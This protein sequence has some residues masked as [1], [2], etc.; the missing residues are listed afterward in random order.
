MPPND[1]SHRRWLPFGYGWCAVLACA[2]TC[3]IGLLFLAHGYYLARGTELTVAALTD[4]G[5][6]ITHDM[7][8][9]ENP[10]GDTPSEP[11]LVRLLGVD[12]FYPVSEVRLPA[13][14]DPNRLM[15]LVAEFQGVRTIYLPSAPLD[16]RSVDLLKRLPALRVVGW[17]E[18][19]PPSVPALKMVT[20]LNQVATLELRGSRLV[21]DEHMKLVV[22]MSNIRELNIER[23]GVT[24]AGLADL[25]ALPRLERLYV[26]EARLSADGLGVLATFPSLK[27]LGIGGLHIS[28]DSLQSLQQLPF[29]E[30]LSLEEMRIGE[31]GARHLGKLQSLRH[32]QLCNVEM[33]GDVEQTL[34]DS[35]PNCSFLRFN[36]NFIPLDERNDIIE[37]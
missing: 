34:R 8:P 17:D 24:N 36:F 2:A 33:S 19:N 26:S 5:A 23:S 6:Q 12:F 7:P 28:D 30:V 16:S 21:D 9:V 11:W 13:D 1:T 18:T 3:T 35:L 20:Q 27:Q 15:P 31:A 22:T 25:A 37:Q 29:L 10:F 32:L 14:V 4:A